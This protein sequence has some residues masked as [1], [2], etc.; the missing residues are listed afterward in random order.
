MQASAATTAT[1]GKKPPPVHARAPNRPLGRNSRT[2]MKIRKMP[3]WP[4]DFA[5][6]E[7]AQALD[8]ADEQAAD[9]RARNR[10]HAAEH[11]GREGDE[12]EGIADMRIDVDR[13][14]S[15]GRPRRRRRRCRG[16][17]SRRRCA[18]RRCRTSCAPSFSLATARMALPVSVSVSSSHSSERDDDGAAKSDEARHRNEHAGNRHDRKAVGH[19]DRCACRRETRTAAHSR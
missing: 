8:H 10:A 1:I 18:R 7:P 3:I 4:S 6:I 19:V 15:A 5:E 2:R 14:A 11:D 16:R 13:S 12:H 17:R 9:Q